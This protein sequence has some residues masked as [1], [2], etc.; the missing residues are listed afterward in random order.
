MPGNAQNYFC[1]F[2]TSPDMEVWGL[3]VTAAGFTRV[4]PGMPYPPA[5]HPDDHQLDWRRGRVLDALQVV[6]VTGGRGQFETKSTGLREIGAGTAF[7]LLP[8]VWHRYRPDPETGWGESWLEVRGPLPERLVAKGVFSEKDPVRPGALGAGMAGALAQ[9][10]G[11]SRNGP[12]GFDSSRAAAACAVL[13]AWE[14]A[15]R[16]NA[17]PVTRLARAVAAAERFLAE[18]HAEPVEVRELAAQLGV[19]YSHFRK[20]F[21]DHTGFAPWQYVLHLRLARAR[22]LLA[23]TDMTLDEMAARLGFSS[24][25]HLSMMFKRTHGV[26]PQG[27]RAG[28]KGEKL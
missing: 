26:S 13:A 21:R 20:A 15:G 2:A 28:E 4:S 19:A 27:W 9:V 6:L 3:T 24:G 25:F 7:A 11:Y 10:H 5:S 1:Y 18:H 22:R 17:G 23:S 8:G 16:E 12:P 14:R